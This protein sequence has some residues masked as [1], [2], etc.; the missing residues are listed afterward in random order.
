MVYSF[1]TAYMHGALMSKVTQSAPV[2][3]SGPIPQ[4]VMD[5]RFRFFVEDVNAEIENWNRPRH[6]IYFVLFHLVLMKT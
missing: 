2:S 5:I 1:S 6:S 3:L 4:H